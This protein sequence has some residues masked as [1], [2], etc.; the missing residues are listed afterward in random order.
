MKNILR[1]IAYIVLPVAAI[2]YCSDQNKSN[3]AKEYS[4]KVIAELEEQRENSGIYPE[5]LSQV[6]AKLGDP[7][8]PIKSTQYYFIEES[9]YKLRFYT[10]GGLFPVFYSYDSLTKDW[11]IQD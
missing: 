1:I 10:V 5:S 11:D 6:Y 3:V 2:S 8:P 7:P 4:Q 9:G